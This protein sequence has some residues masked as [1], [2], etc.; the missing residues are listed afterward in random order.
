M[1]GK[2]TVTSRPEQGTAFHL[3]VPCLARRGASE[4]TGEE[5]AA[6]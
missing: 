5:R 4:G 2:L 3:Y 1:A 6:A